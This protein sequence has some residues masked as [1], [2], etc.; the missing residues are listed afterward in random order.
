VSA[1]SFRFTKRPGLVESFRRSIARVGDLP[2]DI[3]LA[4]HPEF[5]GLSRKLAQ[6]AQ[7]ATPDPFVDAKACRAYADAARRSLERRIAEER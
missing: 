4:V 3:L 1:P 7:G 2:C 6:R 5:A